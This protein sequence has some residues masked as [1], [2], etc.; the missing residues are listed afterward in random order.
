MR[1]PLVDLPPGLP[2]ELDPSLAPARAAILR[3]AADLRRVPDETLDRPRRWRPL[4]LE[5]VELRYGAYRVVER[6]LAG[7]GRLEALIVGRDP[8]VL[9]ARFADGTDA[10]R[11][12][13]GAIDEIGETVARMPAA[14]R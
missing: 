2:V 4:D 9:D 5:D 6:L 13:V 14:G 10:R 3:A 12:A 11:I 7:Y 8:G 1:D